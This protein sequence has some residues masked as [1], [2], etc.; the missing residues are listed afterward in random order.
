[1]IQSVQRQMASANLRFTE[2]SKPLSGFPLFSGWKSRLLLDFLTTHLVIH[3]YLSTPQNPMILPLP[4]A[5][6]P[7][8]LS[9]FQGW[10]K[11]ST[12]N[13]SILLLFPPSNS[14]RSSASSVPQKQL[15]VPMYSPLL[16]S[17][18]YMAIAYFL[19]CFSY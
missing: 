15:P 12:L 6:P 14:K 18:H 10:E 17:S 4:S 7:S 5:L 2:C 8:P 3:L 13:H 16:H 11:L 19:V 9:W 1:M